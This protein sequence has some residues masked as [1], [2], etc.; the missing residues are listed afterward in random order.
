MS[1]LQFEREFFARAVTR[2]EIECKQLL[3][4]AQKAPCLGRVQT[5]LLEPG[6]QIGLPGDVLFGLS[7]VAFGQRQMF[8]E[9]FAVHV[10]INA[11]QARRFPRRRRE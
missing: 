4:F 7:D 3:E 2:G 11:T 8:S 10:A 6:D 1:V 9:S 5:M